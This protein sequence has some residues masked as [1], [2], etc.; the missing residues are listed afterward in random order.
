MKYDLKSWT[1]V[2]NDKSPP[3]VEVSPGEWHIEPGDMTHYE[4]RRMTNGYVF[5]VGRDYKKP[6]CRLVIVI[7]SPNFIHAGAFDD[8]RKDYE[9][10]IAM[11]VA[12]LI[13]GRSIEEPECLASR[14]A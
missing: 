6:G 1:R 5:R 12:G 2:D 13:E 3:I 8:A 14:R 9:M 4:I 10:A 11:F 7:V